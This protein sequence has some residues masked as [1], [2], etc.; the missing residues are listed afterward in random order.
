MSNDNLED[1]IRDQRQDFDGETPPAGLWDRIEDAI[2]P[3]GEDCD[4][5]CE[6][7]ALHRDAFDDATPPP[8]LE[9]RVF[10]S[11]GVSAPAL[12][13]LPNKRRSY[14]FLL[15]IAASMLLLVSGA[16]FLGS[17]T[18]Y[19]AGQA[20]RASTDLSAIDPELAEAEEY[21][22]SEIAA[23]FTRVNNVN[24]DPQL[25]LDLQEL[26]KATAEIREDLL[27]VP[28]SQRSV[29]VNQLIGNYR[30]KLDILLRIQQHI[31]KRGPALPTNEDTD[32]L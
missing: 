8:Q 13:A 21:Y 16:F 2:E 18:G 31:P 20:D 28:V 25:R 9:G 15:G 17:N 3:D 27:S 22:Q 30:T 32:E 26:D 24:S 12:R 4:P 7:I 11:L 23:Q 29:L 10:A 1:F 6:F 14:T 19:R 5:L